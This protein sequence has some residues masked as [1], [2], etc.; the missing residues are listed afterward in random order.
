MNH[1]FSNL[2]EGQLMKIMKKLDSSRKAA[3]KEYHIVLDCI[4]HGIT[5]DNRSQLIQQVEDLFRDQ[6]KKDEIFWIETFNK[7]QRVLGTHL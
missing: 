3:V 1:D 2:V 4:N 6:L 7:V 5:N